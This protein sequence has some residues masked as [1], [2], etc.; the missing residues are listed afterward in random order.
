MLDGQS[1][2]VGV[3]NEFASRPRGKTELGENLPTLRTMTQG[4]C[5][6][7]DSKCSD[8][9]Q[10]LFRHKVREDAQMPGQRV[11]PFLLPRRSAR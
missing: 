8:E 5:M 11:T 2:L 10:S 1:R 3:G 7:S 6:R 9:S 4:P